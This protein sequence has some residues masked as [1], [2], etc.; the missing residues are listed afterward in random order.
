MHSL[1]QIIITTIFIIIIN[2]VKRM[3][4]S[5]LFQWINAHRQINLSLNKDSKVVYFPLVNLL[6][7]NAEVNLDPRFSLLTLHHL[8]EP[9]VVNIWFHCLSLLLINSLWHFFI[10]V[11]HCLVVPFLETV[12]KKVSLLVSPTQKPLVKHSKLAVIDIWAS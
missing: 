4:S 11:L 1:I 9:A 8:E 5:H 10:K 3:F 6:D 7:Y 12:H 2:S